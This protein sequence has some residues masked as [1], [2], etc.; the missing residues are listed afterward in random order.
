MQSTLDHLHDSSLQGSCSRKSTYAPQIKTNKW[1]GCSKTA[2]NPRVTSMQMQRKHS[3]KQAALNM[4]QQHACAV[5]PA[6][7]QTNQPVASCLLL[8]KLLCHSTK[9]TDTHDPR[10]KHPL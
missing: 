3:Q 4:L 5:Y 10:N 6:K 8:Y 1:M 9:D 2:E 7:D